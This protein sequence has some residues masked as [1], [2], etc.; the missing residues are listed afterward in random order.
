MDYLT[1]KEVAEI[2]NLSE[3]HVRRK[4]K[5]SS[6]NSTERIN[7]SN[8]RTEYMI[9]VSALPENLQTKYYAKLKKG[10]GTAPELREEPASKPVK[11]VI[12]KRFEEYTAEQ[13]EEIAMW[14]VRKFSSLVRGAGRGAGI[15]ICES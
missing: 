9:P 3:R 2:A 14:C 10:A 12:K 4:C 1:V 7:V 15:R 11:K 8:G 5:D 6:L 13:R